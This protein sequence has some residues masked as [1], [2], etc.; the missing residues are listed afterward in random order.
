MVEKGLQLHIAVHGSTQVA[1]PAHFVASAGYLDLQITQGLVGRPAFKVH[2]VPPGPLL[3][4]SGLIQEGYRLGV[5]GA[6]I[7][8]KHPAEGI[9][10]EEV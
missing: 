6:L 1:M 3:E 7:Q 10:V 5:L 8:S 2:C 9:V 4:H